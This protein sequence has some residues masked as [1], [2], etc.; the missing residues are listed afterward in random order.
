MKSSGLK[1]YN[2]KKSKG[3]IVIQGD[4]VSE[5]IQQPELLNLV[6]IGVLNIWSKEFKNHIYTF[7]QSRKGMKARH[8]DFGLFQYNQKTTLTKLRE[9]TRVIVPVNEKHPEWYP[10]KFKLKLKNFEDYYFTQDWAKI[11]NRFY[12]SK[13]RHATSCRCCEQEFVEEER[14]LLNL[15]HKVTIRNGGDN[16]FL[17]LVSLCVACHSL[18]HYDKELLIESLFI[19]YAE[20]A[21]IGNEKIRRALFKYDDVVTCF[22]QRSYLDLYDRFAEKA[23]RREAKIFFFHKIQESFRYRRDRNLY[24]YSTYYFKVSRYADAPDQENWIDSS[25]VCCESAHDLIVFAYLI[26]ALIERIEYFKVRIHKLQEIQKSITDAKKSQEITKI[27]KSSIRSLENT[28]EELRYACER[29]TSYLTSGYVTLKTIADLILLV[30]N[31]HAFATSSFIS[32]NPYEKPATKDKL[33]FYEAALTRRNALL[34]AIINVFSP[35][36]DSNEQE[37][38]KFIDTLKSCVDKIGIT[39]SQQDVLNY[40]TMISKNNAGADANS[41]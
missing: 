25:L 19:F 5:L 14:L 10:W 12:N 31:N 22:S 15:H 1:F 27:I 35:D 24:T 16:T 28:N 21:S 9:L 8:R 7:I 4:L 34:L 30:K 3:T 13:N 39:Y 37:L 38:S 20:T 41:T 11:R 2:S 40:L 32:V 18:V 33:V 6:D 17:N 29:F 36:I 23:N 26:Y